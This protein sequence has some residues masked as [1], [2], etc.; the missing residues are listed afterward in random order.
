M[1]PGLTSR[2]MMPSAWAAARPFE[3][4]PGNARYIAVKLKPEGRR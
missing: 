2:W 3:A 1:L 4:R